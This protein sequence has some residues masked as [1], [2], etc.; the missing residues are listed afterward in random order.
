MV[1]EGDWVVFRMIV[2]LLL[3][4]PVH[5][6]PALASDYEDPDRAKCR[7]LLERHRGT[8]D[9]SAT[10]LRTAASREQKCA[11]IR[12]EMLPTLEKA[13][14]QLQSEPACQAKLLSA[15]FERANADLEKAR[16][17]YAKACGGRPAP[18]RD[19]RA[20]VRD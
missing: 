14:R 3:V 19:A 16:Q 10:R 17:R 2:L 11:L 13:V 20:S 4:A 6:G 8:L 18:R 7:N 15:V 9:Q 5:A 12:R 1:R